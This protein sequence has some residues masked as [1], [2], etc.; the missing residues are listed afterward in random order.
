MTPPV[1]QPAPQPVPQPGPVPLL[2]AAFAALDAAGVDWV[3]LSGSG[4]APDAHAGVAVLV[5]GAAAPRLDALLA[6]AGYRRRPGAGPRSH[7][8][9]LGYDADQDSWTT[10]DVV[11]EVAFGRRSEFMT[12]AA[13]ALLGG[14]RRRDGVAL[15]APDDAFWHLLLHYL[16]DKRRIPAGGEAW[17]AAAAA[18]TGCDS[19]LAAVVDGLR[20]GGRS[21]AGVLALVCEGDRTAVAALSAPLRRAWRAK[22]RRRVWGRVARS[23][24]ERA[25]LLRSGRVRPMGTTV[26]ILGPDGAGKTTLAEALGRSVPLPSRHVYMGVWR[27]YAWDRWMSWLPGARLAARLARL[28]VRSV[29]GSYHRRR[30]RLVLLDRFVTDAAL[31]AADLDWRYRVTTRL[32]QGLSSDPDL[33]LVLDAP[34]EVMFARKGEQGLEVLARDR[35]SYLRLA[36]EH[37]SATVIDATLPPARVQTLAHRAFWRTLARTGR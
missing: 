3:L 32:V 7:R 27:E 22:D 24:L 9:Y 8:F 12:A 23:R 5:A 33:L 35:D 21:A 15:L 11:D 37:P 4:P 20:P 30:G 16:L 36:A 31:P 10:L 26:A 6:G 34:A 18:G 17:L 2:D 14:A 28:A 19:A 25:H 13:P 29:Q 1:P